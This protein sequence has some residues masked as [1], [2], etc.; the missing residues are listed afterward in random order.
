MVS[1]DFRRMV[2]GYGLTTANIPTVFPTTLRLFN[3]M[4]G[5]N[6]ICIHISRNCINFSTSG[7][8][9]SK[10]SFTRCWWRMQGSFAQRKFQWWT[11]NSRCTEGRS[12]RHWRD[13]AEQALLSAGLLARRVEQ[14]GA[15]SRRAYAGNR[16]R[17]VVI[18]QRFG[19]C[20]HPISS[21]VCRYCVG[22]LLWVNR[23]RTTATRP[24]PGHP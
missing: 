18:R 15:R 24:R 12:C 5:R 6:T 17:I 20:G 4:S 14:S 11:P 22:G 2:E 16:R 7:H 1:R 13:P 21:E 3:P 10:A 8:R 9:A 23:R 19:A